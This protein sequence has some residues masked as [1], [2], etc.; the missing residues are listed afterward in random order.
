MSNLVTKPSPEASTERWVEVGKL[1]RRRYWVKFIQQIP[2]PLVENPSKLDSII[3]CYGMYHT[4]DGSLVK[5]GKIIAGF[6]RDGLI[7]VELTQKKD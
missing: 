5:L 6:I 2:D 3:S 4:P 7:P 1:D